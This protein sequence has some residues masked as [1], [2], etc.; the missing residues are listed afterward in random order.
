MKNIKPVWVVFDAGGVL[1]NFDKAITSA[2]KY[3]GITKKEFLNSISIKSRKVEINKIHYKDA[4]R[5]ILSSLEMDHKTSDV[6]AILFDVEKYVPDTLSLVEELHDVGY[7]LAI[8]TNTWYGVTKDLTSK[9]KEFYLFEHVFDSAELGLRKPDL[10]IFLYVEKTLLAKEDE[11][12]II[13]DNIL[14][15]KTA[16]KLKWQTFHYSIGNDGGFTSN[17]SIRKLLID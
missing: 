5:E 10:E 9:L 14:N 2:S 15:I 7:S 1:F 8:L 16:K 13:D 12:L 4:W 17:N 3:L 6:L 11:I